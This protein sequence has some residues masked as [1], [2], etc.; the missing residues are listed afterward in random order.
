MWAPALNTEDELLARVLNGLSSVIDPFVFPT[1]ASLRMASHMEKIELDAELANH[2]L[3][4][5]EIPPS[6]L[7]Q[8][9]DGDF[10]GAH[11]QM[12]L[13]VF[14]LVIHRGLSEKVVSMLDGDCSEAN[15]QLC[16]LLAGDEK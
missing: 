5:C 9:L 7:L 12:C 3:I 4:R 15:I 16:T 6:L 14:H 1:D 11:M 10:T 2:E 8:M 13:E